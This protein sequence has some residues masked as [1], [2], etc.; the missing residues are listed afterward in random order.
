MAQRHLDQYKFQRRPNAPEVVGLFWGGIVSEDYPRIS[1]PQ[2][3]LATKISLGKA[4]M[5]Y[6]TNNRAMATE[7]LSLFW[8]G[9]TP[10]IK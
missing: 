4:F 9:F 7:T 5:Q 1:P 2:K 6:L 3:N 10:T 8:G